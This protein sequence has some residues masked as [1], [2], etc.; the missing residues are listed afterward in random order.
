MHFIL[1]IVGKLN[2]ISGF[3]LLAEPPRPEYL[4]RLANAKKRKINVVTLLS[5][6]SV[7]FWRVKLPSLILSF[8]VALLWT[9]V[10][11]AVVF[12]IVLYRM[13]LVTSY[14]LHS[15]KSSYRIYVVP[16]TAGLL[17]L[18]CII[19]LNFM[20]DKLAVWLTEMELQR[21]Q[22]EYDESLALKNYMFQFVNYYSSIFYIAFFKGKFVG[23]PAKYNRIFGFRQ[24][25]VSHSLT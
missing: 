19:I 18:F 1:K 9:F 7:P 6:P 21:T 22:T 8:T 10:A 12:G 11:L 2:F 25:E 13:S 16:I 3:D 17:N 14:A 4:L 15:D 5:E 20:Y 24:E 23:Y